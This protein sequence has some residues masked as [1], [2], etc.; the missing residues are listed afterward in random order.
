MKLKE[1][2][3]L[4][5]ELELIIEKLRRSVDLQERRWLQGRALEIFETIDRSESGF[6]SKLQFGGAKDE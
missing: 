4:K 2:F 1:M 6:R 5:D 3:K